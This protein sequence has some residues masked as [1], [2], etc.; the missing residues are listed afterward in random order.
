MRTITLE[1]HYATEAFMEGPGRE[2]KAQAEAARSHPQVASGYEKLIEQLCGL[3]GGREPAIDEG[4]IALASKLMR[5][6]ETPVSAVCEAVGVSRATLYRYVG[7]D[8]T[9]RAR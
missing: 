1:E 2:L 9:P 3:G 8:G 4:K 5:D 6:R 7:P